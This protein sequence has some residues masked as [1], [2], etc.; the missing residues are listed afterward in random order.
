M[1]RPTFAIFAQQYL[2]ALLSDFGT[3]F[4]NEPIPRDP[5]LRVYKHPSRLNWGTEYLRAI[6]A[7]SRVMISPEIIG[8]A[9]LVDVLFEP[10]PNKS[11]ASLGLLGELTSA[12]CIIEISRW[13]PSSWEIRT[14]M[15]H[16]LTW[17]AEDGG[18]IIPVDEPS[19]NR[20]EQDHPEGNQILLII[21]PSIAPK[22]FP[23]FGIQP[24]A[25]NIPGV[26]AMPPAFHTNIVVTS[27]LPLGPST[28]WLR[29]LGRGPTQ[30][31][32]IQEL[33][34]PNIP[35]PYYAVARQQ[36]RNWYKI[37]LECQIGKE[38]KQLMETLA[39]IDGWNEVQI[40]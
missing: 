40:S 36:L 22:H 24:S 34:T 10:D 21:L 8:E 37:L 38:S 27:E 33:V 20:D 16:W 35:H 4:L 31:K 3:V 26:Y 11:R 6:T 39:I 14:Y 9:D 5:K 12:P 7:G 32:A 18:V 13:T 2:Y 19:T 23:G 28:L 25:M 17:K 1:A 29:L 15:Q 30:R